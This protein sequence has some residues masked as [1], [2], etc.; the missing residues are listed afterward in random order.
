[1]SVGRGR[2]NCI[3]DILPPPSRAIVRDK[4]GPLSPSFSPFANLCYVWVVVMLN[5][6]GKEGLQM[7]GGLRASVSTQQYVF[8][9]GR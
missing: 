7:C 6:K 4:G 8:D 5:R 3:Y 2:G 9:E 1:M